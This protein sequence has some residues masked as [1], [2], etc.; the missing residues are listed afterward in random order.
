LAGESKVLAPGDVIAI[1]PNVSRRFAP[2]MS[3]EASLF[4]VRNTDDPAGPTLNF[5]T[6]AASRR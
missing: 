3:G 4:R 2:S 5:N 1:P 6:P